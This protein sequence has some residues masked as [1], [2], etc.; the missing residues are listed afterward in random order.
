MAETNMM[1]SLSPVCIV[2]EVEGDTEGDRRA[3]GARARNARGRPEA[4]GLRHFLICSVHV[5]SW[6]VLPT[7]TLTQFVLE[8][9][10]FSWTQSCSRRTSS[11]APTQKPRS[12]A[13]SPSSVFRRC[14]SV[15]SGRLAWLSPIG[16]CDCA[17][18]LVLYLSVAGFKQAASSWLRATCWSQWAAAR[19]WPTAPIVWRPRRT[20]TQVARGCPNHSVVILI[21]KYVCVPTS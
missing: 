9:L 19:P 13:S 8:Y 20:R 6:K 21:S 14:F 1:A 4:Y 7:V 18:D 3:V 15:R 5:D 11:V 16:I 12:R 2:V 17:S 10:L